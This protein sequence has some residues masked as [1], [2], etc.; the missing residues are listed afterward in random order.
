MV[1]IRII[2]AEN[3]EIYLEG[4]KKIIEEEPN[5]ELVCTC[6]PGLDIIKKSNTYKPDIVLMDIKAIGYNYADIIKYINQ[7]L[8]QTK[9]IILTNV[10][11]DGNFASYVKVGLKAYLS[12]SISRENL[13]KCIN[14]VADG[15]FILSPPELVHLRKLLLFNDNEV[16]APDIFDKLGKRERVV[17]SLVSEGLTNREIAHKLY[18][19][20]NTVKVHMRNIMEKLHAHTRQEAVKLTVNQKTLPS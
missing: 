4:L 2:I 11:T 19:S 3:A 14:L 17:L 5:L 18:L 15:K 1:K 10:A 9:I 6:S 20:E 13:V 7:Q 8:P 16:H 12:K